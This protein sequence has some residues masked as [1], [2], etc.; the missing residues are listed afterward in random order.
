MQFTIGKI[1]MMIR[2]STYQFHFEKFSI[3]KIVSPESLQSI[4][5]KYQEPQGLSR[6]PSRI[7]I[8]HECEMNHQNFSS[9]SGWNAGRKIFLSHHFE[10]SW[11]K[12]LWGTLRNKSTWHFKFD[13][14]FLRSF[15]MKFSLS[16]YWISFGN[17][18]ESLRDFPILLGGYNLGFHSNHG[19]WT[20]LLRY[21]L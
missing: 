15:L 7:I 11:C 21:N 19:L 9:K 18:L 3:E 8:H 2:L 16:F 20:T 10:D 13:R 12:V 1:I 17:L 5:I 6:N 4:K 14:D